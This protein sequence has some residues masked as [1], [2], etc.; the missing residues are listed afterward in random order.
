MDFQCF[1]FLQELL[2]IYIKHSKQFFNRFPNTSK[3]V[4]EIKGKKYSAACYFLSTL[5]D[6]M[7][8]LSCKVVKLPFEIYFTIISQAMKCLLIAFDFWTSLV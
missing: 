4:K 6:A 3:L 1:E 8:Y 5:L 7:K 2:M